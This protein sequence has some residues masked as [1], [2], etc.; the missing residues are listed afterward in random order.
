M[1]LYDAG[2]KLRNQVTRGQ[3][4][5]RDVLYVDEKTGWVWFKANITEPGRFQRDDYIYRVK[6][7][8]TGLALL[9]PE[10]GAH[11]FTFAPH[12]NFFIDTYSTPSTAPVTVLRNVADGKITLE[13]ERADLSRLASIHWRAPQRFEALSADG[14][15]PVYGF[16]YLPRDFDSTKVYP[17]IDHIYP[18]G[19]VTA[20]RRSWGFLAGSYGDPQALAEL[21]FVV[22][23]MDGRGTWTPFSRSDR[24]T[25][26]R[27]MGQNS[28]PDHV[29]AI[30]Q[31]GARYRWMDLTR[32]GIYGHSG[33][34]YASTAGILRY[35]DFYKV[36][37][38][39]DGLT[40][41]SRHLT[42]SRAT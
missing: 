6:L 26:Y 21:G 28:L 39:S 14:V 31:L 29:T 17:V 36:A 38:S 5:I 34:G 30:K 4:S 19:G 25:Y 1:Y 24:D 40:R 20:Y 13:L 2:G 8:G 18:H 12:G 15:T 32:V 11:S 16:I 23:Q 33:G 7:D 37:V 27:H 3:F 41:P 35:P 22:V 42:P 10:P 9:T